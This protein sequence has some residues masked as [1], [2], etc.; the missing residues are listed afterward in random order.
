MRWPGCGHRG[1]GGSSAAGGYL[2][3]AG[4]VAVTVYRAPQAGV[5][6]RSIPLARGYALISEEREVD[7][8]KGAAV[9]RFEGVAAG[10]LA[11]SA[12]ISGLPAGLAKNL[13]AAAFAAQPL[14][15]QLRAACAAAPHR[16]ARPCA[17]GA[18]DHPI[19]PDGAAV[20]QTKAGFELANCGG[21]NDALWPE[22]P[23]DLNAAHA[24]H[25]HAMRAG[26][27]PEAAAFLSGLGF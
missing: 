23:Q 25:R 18:G 1:A 7:L 22:A 24:F 26:A 19:G 12:I 6:S 4:P 27:A 8:P 13:D 21:L 17:R 16:C 3:A 20:V 11:E 5:I 10:M 9:L 14:C 2:G 15:A